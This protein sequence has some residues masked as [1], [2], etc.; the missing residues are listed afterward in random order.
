[1]KEVKITN[2]TVISHY[3]KEG[4]PVVIIKEFPSKKEGSSTITMSFNVK[5]R[6][7]AHPDRKGD[8]YER[9][10]FF[11]KNEEKASVIRDTIQEG[12]LIEISGR[13]ESKSSGKD[14]GKFYR[15]IVVENIVPITSGAKVEPTKTADEDLPF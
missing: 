12:A 8:L 1:M 7:S 6:S 14:D 4:E 2:A 15:S 10:V 5:T 9:C 3:K 13:E 11:A